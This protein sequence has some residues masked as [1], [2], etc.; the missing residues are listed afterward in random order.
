MRRL[1]IIS[2]LLQ[3]LAGSVCASAQNKA[4]RNAVPGFLYESADPESDAR[5]I[6]EV[7]SRLARIRRTRPTV[8]LVLSGGG[9]K[10]AAHVGVMKYREEHGSDAH[11]DR[12]DC[13]HEYGWPDGRNVCPGL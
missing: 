1:I 8:A 2:A 10:G 9:A 7:R 3:L 5:A 4:S 6:S 13:R 12:P 11:P